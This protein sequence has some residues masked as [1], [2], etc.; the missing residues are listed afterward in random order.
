M[1]LWVNTFSLLNSK[2]SFKSSCVVNSQLVTFKLEFLNFC[3]CNTKSECFTRRRECKERKKWS[4]P[5]VMWLFRRPTVPMSCGRLLQEAF[6]STS[7]APNGIRCHFMF[8]QTLFSGMKF[9]WPVCFSYI[10]E[11]MS[12]TLYKSAAAAAAFTSCFLVSAPSRLKH[13]PASVQCF[14]FHSPEVVFVVW[15]QNRSQH[16]SC[17]FVFLGSE[18]KNK[19]TFH[20][21][22]YLMLHWSTSDQ[23]KPSCVP[24]HDLSICGDDMRQSIVGT[25]KK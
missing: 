9:H 3:D 24:S 4:Q 6:S 25:R 11:M 14:I 8:S 20:A 18:K 21:I 19:K 5:G 23:R 13:I 2:I 7:A 12:H 15:R 17:T 10:P 22:K 16:I 1:P